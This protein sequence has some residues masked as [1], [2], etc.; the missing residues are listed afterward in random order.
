MITLVTGATG[1][2]GS[3]VV[4]ALR[5][6]DDAVRVLIRD[7]QKAD[8]FRERGMEVVV[9]DL[10]DAAVMGEAVRGVNVIHHC[11]AAVG[12]YSKKE[13]YATNLGGVR[14]LLDAVRNAG[15]ARIVLLSS[16]N[17]LG[18][19][20]LDPATEVTPYQYSGDP[21]ADVKI[22]AEKLALDYHRQFGVDV[23][24]LRPCFIYGPRDPH[25]LPKL[26]S[27]MQR[28]KFRFIGSRDNIVPIVHVEDV[29]RAMLLAAGK[30]AARGR[31]YQ[32]SDGSRTSIGDLVNQL[33]ELLHCPKPEKVLP[34][35]V[36]RLGC[37]VFEWLQRLGLRKKPGPVTRASLRFVGTSRYIDIRRAR[38]ELGYTPQI[39]LQ[40]GLGPSV[41]QIL[42]NSD[43]GAPAV[44]AT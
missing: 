18:T 34:Y 42:E 6:R 9:G 38:E 5:E 33:A 31:I 23:T 22:E 28:G 36:P 20:N 19:R 29:A 24:I 15:R 4:D 40:E 37:S 14:T 26:I 2:V 32:I 27:S 35:L 44:H 30:P 1:F 16:V 13:I 21:A 41:S 11:G 17:V 39:T 25:N 8:G 43:V 12:P 7:G 10:R 3:H